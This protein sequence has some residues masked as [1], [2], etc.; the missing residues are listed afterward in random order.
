MGCC[1]SLPE[2]PPPR[3]SKSKPKGYIVLPNGA[4]VKPRTDGPPRHGREH[5]HRHNHRHSHNHGHGH[6]HKHSHHHGHHRHHHRESSPSGTTLV[7]NQG[8]PEAG[9]EQ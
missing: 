2:P 4:R 7:P 5:S 6:G 1:F 9:N 8:E 3:R